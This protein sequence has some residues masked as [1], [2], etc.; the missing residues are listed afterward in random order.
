[1]VCW[2]PHVLLALR[3]ARDPSH[4]ASPTTSRSTTQPTTICGPLANMSNTCQT[5][6]ACR[7]GVKAS[8]TK[9]STAHSVSGFGTRCVPLRFLVTFFPAAR[10]I[11]RFIIKQVRPQKL[12]GDRRDA[13]PAQGQ[14]AEPWNDE[15]TVRGRLQVL[16]PTEFDGAA[17]GAQ[18][19]APFHFTGFS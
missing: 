3:T 6:I 4:T 8:G 1:M 7:D 14:A 2:C 15:R 5:N 12:G 11:Y 13:G 17:F 10:L 16:A 9:P 18:P 19:R